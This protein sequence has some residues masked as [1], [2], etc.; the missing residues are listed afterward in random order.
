MAESVMEKTKIK[1]RHQANRGLQLRPM[2]STVKQM[3]TISLSRKL[4]GT[5]FTRSKSKSTRSMIT[6]ATP[7]PCIT[8]EEEKA[9]TDEIDIIYDDDEFNSNT[10]TQRAR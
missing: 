7:L 6:T 3:M 2:I 5:T 4:T 9:Q 8:E 10:L 1:E